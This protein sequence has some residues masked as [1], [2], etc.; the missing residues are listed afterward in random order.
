MLGTVIVAQ[1]IL[2]VNPHFRDLCH[3]KTFLAPCT[4][5]ITAAMQV[6]ALRAKGRGLFWKKW[7]FTAEILW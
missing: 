4:K 7:L 2:D 6:H 3:D 5:I 1:K